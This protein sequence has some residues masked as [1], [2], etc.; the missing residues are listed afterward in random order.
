MSS[1]PD[2][3]PVPDP[4]RSFETHWRMNPRTR[5]ILDEAI[6][7]AVAA[8]GGSPIDIVL[9]VG[10]GRQSNVVFPG[11]GRVVGTD[12][13]DE[14]LAE[15]RTISVGILADVGQV[16]V[17]EQSVD[18]IAC[19]YVLEHVD[20]PDRV[21]GK[22]ARALRPD[23][24]LVLAIPNTAAP[25]ARVTRRTPLWFHRFVY[26]RL[27]GRRD[28]N[29]GHP[30]PT[31][32]DS[33]IRP[34]RIENLAAICGLEVVYRRDFEDNKQ[35]QLRERFHLE[36]IVW[37]GVRGA[38]RVVTGGRID[39]ELSDVVFTLHRPVA[40]AVGTLA[41]ALAPPAVSPSSP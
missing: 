27:L 2:D 19:I 26:E 4:A 30:F 3:A 36:G 40:T 12:I 1:A 20:R 31:V 14:G 41:E 13:D 15:N 23:G 38:M 8:R 35:R 18:A 9:D 37:K 21:L 6:A 10:C 16:D 28:P 7:A 5:A 24:V 33:S 32:L 34:D 25:K 11:A 17:P 39:P 22:L 29:T